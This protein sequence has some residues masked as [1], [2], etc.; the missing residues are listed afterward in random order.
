MLSPKDFVDQWEQVD[1]TLV[2]FPMKAL[3]SLSI[4]EADKTFLSQAGLPESAAPFLSFSAPD[5]GELPTV[6][7]LWNL[8]EAFAAFREIGS[9]GAGNSIA[10]DENKNGEVVLIDHDNDFAR[11]LVNKSVSQLAE[12]L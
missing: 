3:K 5:S 4:S 1:E 7:A 10:L 9:D 11:I 6:A 2:R 8:A 12:S